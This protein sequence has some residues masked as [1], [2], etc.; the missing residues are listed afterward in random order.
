M[1]ERLRE[2]FDLEPTLILGHS[3]IFEVAVN[4]RVVSKKTR[5][6]FPGTEEAVQAV[7]RAL[8]LGACGP[9]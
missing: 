9:A 7:A 6:G 4:G 1:A 3:G 5:D 2:E 8:E